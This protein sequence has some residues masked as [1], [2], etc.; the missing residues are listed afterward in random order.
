MTAMEKDTPGTE[1][2]VPVEREP[3]W[4][5]VLR[6]AP[7]VARLLVDVV[8][9]PRVPLRDKIVAGATAAYLI[10]PIDVIP[11]VLPIIGRLDDAAVIAIALRRL[12]ATAGHDVLRELWRGTDEGW[13]A[14]MIVGGFER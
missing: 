6:F 9:D 2:H 10:S 8:R 7:D 13:V 14:L 12:L 3:T 11:D 5:Q 1:A 4:K